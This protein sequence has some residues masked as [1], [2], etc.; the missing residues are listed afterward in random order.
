[1]KRILKA[2]LAFAIFSIS[3][4]AFAKDFDWSQSWC[5]YGGNIKQGDFLLNAN[6]GIP[7]DVFNQS[8]FIPSFQVEFN[9]AQPIWKLPFTFGGYAGMYGF[10]K[11]VNGYKAS[12]FNM[13][14]GFQIAYHVM[15]P[16]EKLDTYLVQRMGLG[17]AL[18]GQDNSGSQIFFDGGFALGASWFFTDKLAATLELGYPRNTL[19]ILFKF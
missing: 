16:P 5:N 8:W 17:I 7:Y 4:T 12:T 1:M 19:G 18:Y 13:Y 9:Y 14:T 6:V 11:N 15:L 3:S 2:L 10:G